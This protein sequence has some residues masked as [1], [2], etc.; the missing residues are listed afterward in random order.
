MKR[1]LK[2]KASAVGS[3]NSQFW[4]RESKGDDA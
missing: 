3:R 2:N 4:K 1:K